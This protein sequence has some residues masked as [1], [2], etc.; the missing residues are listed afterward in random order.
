M[1]T[2]GFWNIDFRNS[3]A[4]EREILRFAADLTLERSLDVLFLIECGASSES[5]LDAFNGETDY[6]PISCAERFTVVARFDPNYMQRLSLP[7]P[8]NRF[9]VWHL[10]LPLQE[11][12]LL[13]LVHGLDKRNNSS[14]RQELF[15][16]QVVEALSYLED[17]VGHNR[18]VVLGDLLISH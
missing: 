11:D 6:Y 8:G 3:D 15:M 12:V 17:K 7:V 5:L 2:F 1:A 16:Q 13:C 10:R 18:T 4:D 9:D 14:R